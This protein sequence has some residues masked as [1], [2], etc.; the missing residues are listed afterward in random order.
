MVF[1]SRLGVEGL[2]EITWRWKGD[3]L[4]QDLHGMNRQPKYSEIFLNTHQ[5]NVVPALKQK[6]AFK[7][8]NV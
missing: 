1:S 7:P 8:A 6:L 2:S 4:R 3:L 5:V